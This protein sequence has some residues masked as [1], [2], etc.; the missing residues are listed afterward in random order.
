MI[1]QLIPRAKKIVNLRPRKHW[2]IRISG[3]WAREITTG[4]GQFSIEFA[5]FNK[6]T[7]RM[8]HSV[9]KESYQLIT[10]GL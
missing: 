4:F 8:A 6:A 9:H 2:E 3:K 1:M 7:H 10:L 5:A